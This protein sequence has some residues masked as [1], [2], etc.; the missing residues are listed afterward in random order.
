VQR[1]F[2]LVEL[3][4]V[5]AII[6]ILVALLLP[7]IQAARE[8]ARRIQC[9]NNMK[10]IGIAI[11]NFESAK[12]TFPLAYTPNFTGGPYS[13][14]CPLGPRGPA[15]QGNMLP[16]HNVIS[17]ILSYM[18]QQALYD[19]IDFDRAWSSLTAAAGRTPNYQ[20]VKATIPDLICP[21]APV[22]GDTWPSDYAVC[23]FINEEPYCVNELSG[24]VKTKRDTGALT[25]LLDDVPIPIRKV[26]DGLSKTFMFFEDAGR[27]IY[28]VLGNETPLTP[29]E[30]SG[31]AGFYSGSMAPEWANPAQYFGF[32]NTLETSCGFTTVMN[33]NNHNEIY[34]FHPGGCVFLYGDGS[35]DFISENIDLDS[36][37][38]L[39]TRASDDIATE[40][41]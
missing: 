21:S 30:P 35:V 22:R 40:R 13:G 2:T 27:P 1:G 38:S 3:L 34:S 31:L 37:I 6:G 18:E 28:Y 9:T 19:Q 41:K 25:G 23:V 36:F 26:T 14:P 29:N 32:G 16:G 20:V 4:V 7:A 8:A 10:Q 24:L 11:L 17:R 39:I 12:R 15:K 33:C 5:I